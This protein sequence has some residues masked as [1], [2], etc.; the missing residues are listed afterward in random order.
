MSGVLYYLRQVYS[1]NVLDARLAP[2]EKSRP[3]HG[4]DTADTT[5]PEEKPSTKP[6]A[7]GWRPFEYYLYIIGVSML[8][9]WMTYTAIDV[10]RDTN[11]NYPKFAHLLSPG[12]IAGR[13]V[14]NSDT[15]YASFRDNI[16]YMSLVLLLHPLLRKLYNSFWRIDTYT[17]VPSIVESPTGL[18]SGLTHAAAADAR[19]QYRVTF[20]LAFAAVF[21]VALHGVS[22]IKVFLLL[23]LN[24]KLA[25]RVPQQYMP[26]ATWTFAIT[27]LFANELCHGYRFADI[28]TLLLPTQTHSVNADWLDSFGGL[29][30]RWE[31]LFNITI[32]R[33]I[34]FNLDY[35]W[36]ITRGPSSP[37]EVDFVQQSALMSTTDAHKKKQ[38]DPSQL[39]ERDR[40][41]FGARSDEYS[42]R[43]YV[44]YALYSPLYL[45][46]PIITFNDYISQNKHPLSTVTRSR[47]IKY[48]I[49]FIVVVLTME[50]VLHFVYAVAI[51]K[52]QPTWTVYT[53]FQLS[54][55][56][57]FNLHI[58]WLKLLIP[59]R[60]FRLWSL[61]DGIDPPENMIRC[62]SDNYSA[63][64][65]WR[66]WHRSFNK[67]ILRYIYIPLGGGNVGKV[68]GMLNFVAVFTFVALWHD[69]N[70][71]LLMWGWL[72]VLFI[73]PE[74]ICTLSFPAKKWNERPGVY[75]VICGIG[76]VGN[77]IMMMA[78][79]LVGF[80]IGIDG[81]QGLVKGILGS[82][83]GIGFLFSAIGTL[84]LGVQVMFEIR[85]R[86]ASK[87]I[88]LKC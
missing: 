86:E 62:M 47:N 28:V 9:P 30:P 6:A 41:N 75:R 69:V 73:L 78:A 20:D 82:W 55:L 57:Y 10:S 2:L 3:S 59:W 49:R 67:W 80:A 79:N 15:Q 8:V 60:F 23:W 16:P 53:P 25:T 65:F 18:S 33:L 1:T 24:F 45:A 14:D 40:I 58:I 64:A 11:V 42:F 84:Y 74:V 87:G 66:G 51:C 17:N 19:L 48:G 70:L 83:H 54:M 52:A 76:G 63:L 26:L 39:S 71:R 37:V 29:V 50:V 46:G 72:V 31:I 56:G 5:L 81:L 77:V 34:S 88:N 27:I 44:A 36:T 61:V 21:L 12:W 38:L 22:A 32:L 43:N 7:P 68:R 4:N 13:K 35:Y 85:R